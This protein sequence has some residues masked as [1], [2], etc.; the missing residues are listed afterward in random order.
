MKDLIWGII[1]IIMMTVAAV[2]IIKLLLLKKNGIVVLAEVTAVTEKTRGRA[3]KLDHFVH[4][5][6]YNVAGKDYEVDDRAGYNQPFE[7]GSTQLIV[8]DRRSPEHI[9]YESDLKKNITLGAVLIGV[10]AVFSVRWLISGI[11]SL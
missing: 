1:G 9:E 7:I 2:Y 6:K 10:A 11:S 5:L 4:T 3:K 8:C